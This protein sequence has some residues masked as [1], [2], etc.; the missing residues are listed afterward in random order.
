[1]AVLAIV[2]NI[3]GNAIATAANG[4]ERVL[5]NGDEIYSGETLKASSGSL[6]LSYQ[7]A[8]LVLPEGQSLTLNDDTQLPSEDELG[9]LDSAVA[10]NSVSDVLNLLDGETDLLDNMEAPAAGADGNH[11]VMQLVSLTRVAETFDP[12]TFAP[13]NNV[14][15][16]PIAEMNGPLLDAV[17]GSGSSE[18]AG[19]GNGTEPEDPSTPSV[20]QVGAPSASISNNYD[21]NNDL[22][23]TTITGEAEA[24]SRVEIKDANGDII[25]SGL[26]DAN[27]EYEII[28]TPSLN[29]GQEYEVVAIDAS[30]NASTPTLVV[31]DTEAPAA[32]VLALANDTSNGQAI[33]SDGTLLVS[34]VEEGAKV[35]YSTDGLNWSSQVSEAQEGENT[36][37]VRQTDAAGNQSDSSSISFV[38]DS[39]APGTPQA[40]LSNS[41]SN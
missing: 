13:F 38:V 16:D 24:G 30:G 22:I 9:F 19:A 36:I 12:I 7:G 39:Q 5:M 20:P 8:T 26:A 4:R 18:S 23:S 1:M 33:T 3:S 31:G 15:N 6:E 29:N 21:A 40:E 10:E 28:V 27:G 17:S 41:Y 34:G 14:I 32:P 35:E 2:K 37:Y 25:G 11:G